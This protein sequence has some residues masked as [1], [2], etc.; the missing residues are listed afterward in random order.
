M[1]PERWSR[2]KE[3]FSTASELDAAQRAAYLEEAC[4]DA[5]LRAE[6]A[7]LLQAQQA[8]R[9]VIDRPAVEYLTGGNASPSAERWLGKRIGSYELLALIA[10]GGMGEV[11]RARRADAQ[12]EKEVAIKLVRGGFDVAYVLERFRAERQIL[13]SLDHPNIAR[14]L[15][16]GATEDGLPYLVMELVEGEPIDR[17]CEQHGLAV[18]DRLRLFR[19]VCSAVSY[20]HQRLVVHR[21]LKPSNILVTAGGSVKLLDFGV[22]KLLR[23]G[24]ADP[25]AAPT[26]TLMHALTPTFASP[27]Q[28]LGLAITT[29]SDIYSLGVVLYHLL[30]GRS[31]Y[32]ST[33]LS[34]QDAIREVCEREPARPSVL[35]RSTPGRPHI[36]RDLDVIVLKALRKEPESRYTSVEQLSEDV[37]RHLQGLPVAAR[38][39]E[40]GYRA[41]KFMRRHRVGVAATVILLLA[42]AA[43]VAATLRQ[44][45]IARQ[46][47]S[48][49]QAERARVERRFNDVRKL[50]DALIFD[51]NDAIRNLPGATPARKVLLDRVVEYLDSVARDAAG[52]PDLERELAWGYQRLATVQGS[53]TE[54]SVGDVRAAELSNRKALAHFEAV[55]RARPGDAADQVNLAMMHRILSFSDL[56][57]DAGR[58]ELERAL[59]ITRPLL[60]RDPGNLKAKRELAV[61]YQ[62]L[63]FVQDAAGNRAAA[64]GWYGANRALKLEIMQADP[65]NRSFARSIGMA[66]VILGDAE[67]HM[68][69]LDE[70]LATIGEGIARYEAL[71]KGDDDVNVARELAVSRMKYADVLLMRGDVPGAAAMFQRAR[72]TIEPLARQDPKNAIL[73]D[74]AAWLDYHEG[75]V[76]VVRGRYA[77]GIDK[78]R[79]S[80]ARFEEL[81]GPLH[82]VG[83][84]ANA[85]AFIYVWLGDAHG[86]QGAWR[87]ALQHYQLGIR[88]LG[89][90]PDARTDDD[91]RCKLALGYMRASQ[92]F[93]RLGRWREAEQAVDK[94]LDIIK[95]SL[96]PEFEDVPA[97]YVAAEGYARRAQILAAQRFRQPPAGRRAEREAW[98]QSVALWQ[99]IPNPSS[100]VASNGFLVSSPENVRDLATW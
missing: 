3:L 39:D 4:E 59:A 93:A 55:A 13:A 65:G 22:A 10:R 26:V 20:A 64:L 87:T 92:A 86:S 23:P 31:P 75:K 54:A 85:E 80:L 28:V 73:Q 81:H 53:T 25:G 11:Y 19:E 57:S 14:L 9:I 83:E 82:E 24:G 95:P 38:G 52:D 15:D 8:S 37:L 35:A 71:P 21:D 36:D 66:T 2:L 91:T 62:D 61:E 44:A 18:D 78:L 43:G 42:I 77:P 47:A 72:S 51:I 79:R 60:A 41:G 56:S 49:A 50:S 94:G 99:R 34:T 89:T 96:T 48:L 74:D 76:H 30:A 27:E 40:L 6:L 84:T 70:A 7:S 45:A 17:H 88:V 16:G 33:V 67:G 90:A 100:T 46:Q 1:T 68:N 29:A 58:R 69:R 98:Q 97:L 12:Y 5:E 32:E 63:G